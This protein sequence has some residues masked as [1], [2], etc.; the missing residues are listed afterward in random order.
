[1]LPTEV[2][3]ETK[4]T[5][6]T[7]TR[8]AQTWRRRARQAVLWLWAVVAFVVTGSLASAHEYTL[9]HPARGDRLL[10]AALA[11]QRTPA[12]AGRFSVTHVMYAACSCSQNIVA[13]LA[14]RGARRDVVEHVVLAGRDAELSARITGAGYHLDNI[15]PAELERKYGLQAAPLL[16]IA[17]PGGEITYLGGYSEQKQGVDIRD[18][19]LIDQHIAGQRARE[20]PL[21]GCA[22]SRALQRMLDPFGLKYP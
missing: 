22:V 1:V 18:T 10:N 6:G 5:P 11:A 12:A 9:P 19:A 20:L 17:E 16:I 4:P 14:A 13:H 2:M 3:P 15:E 21:L 7:E 8:D